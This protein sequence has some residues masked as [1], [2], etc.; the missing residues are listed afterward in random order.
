MQKKKV[1][2]SGEYWQACSHLT[3]LFAFFQIAT[4][5]Q[6]L[7]KESAITGSI[8]ITV[9][10]VDSIIRL[11]EA[12]AKLHLRDYV[13]DDDVN[14][15][16]RVMVS[17]FVETQ[18]FSIAKQMQRVFSKYITYKKDN[19]DLLFFVLSQL[20]REELSYQQARRLEDA[21]DRLEVD[22]EDFAQRARQIGVYDLAPFY[23]SNQFLDSGY[24]L[25]ETNKLLVK[26]F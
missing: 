14:M 2:I 3:F 10:Q 7:R 13:R 18:K 17:S 25:D 6:E 11:S 15:A 19:N 16:I 4:L 9:R 24:E 26:Q 21:G 1:S 5:Y 22:S 12:H 23:K 8:P 20:G